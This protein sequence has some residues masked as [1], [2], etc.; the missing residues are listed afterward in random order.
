MYNLN[1]GIYALAHTVLPRVEEG[2]KINHNMMPA[3]YT[4]FAI[5]LMYEKLVQKCNKNNIQ[6]KIVGGGQIYND[7]FKIGERNVRTAIE[8][9]GKLAIK[10][11]SKDVGGSHGRSILSFNSDGSLY[12]RKQGDYFSTAA[13]ANAFGIRPGSGP[14][15]EVWPGCECCRGARRAGVPPF[16]GAMH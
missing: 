9:L 11:V 16:D 7:S 12:L 4:D 5:N 13:R 10:I 2:Y 14:T 8:V 6:C 3:K 15:T 1:K